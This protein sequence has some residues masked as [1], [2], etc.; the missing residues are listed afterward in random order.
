M[1]LSREQSKAVEK[2]TLVNKSATPFWDQSFPRAGSRWPRT[3]D[4]RA[5]L[6]KG[7]LSNSSKQSEG[8]VLLPG[9]R[10]VNIRNHNFVRV[11]PDKYPRLNLAR[12]LQRRRH[13]RAAVR[14]QHN[15]QKKEKSQ[16]GQAA[17][18]KSMEGC[19]WKET[20]FE[21]GRRLSALSMSDGVMVFLVNLGALR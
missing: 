21:P 15:S 19:T 5:F 10:S 11:L 20:V 1:K 7:R 16:T 3:S 2:L 18:G 17:P 4:L 6:G 9:D 12:S 8:E 13:L 14:I